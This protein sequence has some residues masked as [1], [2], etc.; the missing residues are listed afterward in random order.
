M[1]WHPSLHL[2]CRRPN[3][4]VLN[5]FLRVAP[6]GMQLSGNRPN[7]EDMWCI[8]DNTISC[9]S[10][11]TAPWRYASGKIM[12][13]T[14]FTSLSIKPRFSRQFNV[15]PLLTTITDSQRHG[16]SPLQKGQLGLF[17]VAM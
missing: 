7:K 15:P 8:T 4:T 10:W 3:I 1:G 11:P 17:G 12:N 6:V 9:H 5:Y 13:Q 2:P 14:I 16:L